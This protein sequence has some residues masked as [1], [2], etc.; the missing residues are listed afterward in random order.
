VRTVVNQGADG[1]AVKYTDPAGGTIEWHLAY[2]GITDGELASLKQFFLSTEGSLNGFTFLDPTAN[3][4]AW[5][6]DLTNAVW[7]PDPYLALALGVADPRGGNKAWHLTNKADG[8]QAITQILNVPTAYTYCFS[9]YAR[10]LAPAPLT[11]VLATQRVTRALDA[12]WSRISV[13]GNGDPAATS[14]EFGIELPADVAIDLFG[15]QVEAQQAASAYK[16]STTGGVYENARF[17]E[18][19][20][21]LTATDVNS[22]QVSI[23]ILYA[24]HL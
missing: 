7:T 9:A 11:M 13:F 15:P 6:E 1:T 23:N 2:S 18:D 3:L 8:V 4:L 16:M 17:R 24:N 12:E 5:S 19:A 20:L 21:T 22:H 10:S 14:V